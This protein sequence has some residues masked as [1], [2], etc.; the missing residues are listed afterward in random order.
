M[1][2]RYLAQLKLTSS[3]AVWWAL[4]LALPFALALL[5]VAQ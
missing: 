3:V 4:W 1:E 5:K 2:T